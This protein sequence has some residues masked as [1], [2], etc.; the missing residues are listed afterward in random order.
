MYRTLCFN[1]LFYKPNSPVVGQLHRAGL[2]WIVRAGIAVKDSFGGYGVRKRVCNFNSPP[3]LLQRLFRA[4]IN[5]RVGVICITVA[6]A[7]ITV[8]LLPRVHKY[9]TQRDTFRRMLTEFLHS[10][11]I[12]KDTPEITRHA[13]AHTPIP[14][15]RTPTIHSHPDAAAERN[16][17][18]EFVGELALSIGRTPFFMSMARADQKAGYDGERLYYWTK[19][20]PIPPRFSEISPT[21]LVGIVDTDYYIDMPDLLRDN[22][23]PYIVYTIQPENAGGELKDAKYRFVDNEF[24]MI[25]TGGAKFRHEIWD[26]GSDTLS[27]SGWSWANLCYSYT[28]FLLERRNV[29][30]GR[31]LVLLSPVSRYTGL[32]AFL[33]SLFL[34]TPNLG[35]LRPLVGDFNVINL[36]GKE[37]RSVSVARNGSWES[38][39][40]SSRVD[41]TFRETAR[42]AEKQ[43]LGLQ[44]AQ[45]TSHLG[46]EIQ[47]P[48]QAAT[49]LTAYYASH[50]SLN[51][52]PTIY[53]VELAVASYQFSPSKYEPSTPTMK[54][55]MSP[56]L[57]P[58]PAPDNCLSNDER[59]VKMRITSVANPCLKPSSHVIKAM[60][61]FV[62]RLIPPEIRHTG[63]PTGYD[64]VFRRQPRPSQ[65]H[66]LRVADLM[67][68]AYTKVASCF[69]KKEDY[70]KV[71]DPRNITQVPGPEKSSYSRFM[72]AFAEVM[73]VQPWYA[74]GKT[75][76]EI[77]HCVAAIA[78]IVNKLLIS[79]LSRMDGHKSNV[80]R[81][82]NKAAVLLFFH[83]SHA[84]ELVDLMETQY[85]KRG[86]TQFGIWFETW[87][88]QLSGSPDTSI[89]NTLESG[90]IIFL[91]Y[92]CTIN[93]NTC[94]YYTFSE[95]WDCLVT[96]AMAGG[97]DGIAGDL[98]AASYVKAAKLLGHVATGDIVERGERGVTFLSRYYSPDV[99]SGDPA[100]CCDIKRAALKFHTTSRLPET[101][102]PLEKLAEK[103]LAIT[104]TDPNTP[105]LGDFATAFMTLYKLYGSGKATT[106]ER[107]W[108]QQYD[109]DVQFININTGGWMDEEVRMA[110]PEFDLEGFRAHLYQLT[111]LSDFL[112]FPIFQ[113]EP[114]PVKGGHAGVVVSGELGDAPEPVD[115][116]SCLTRHQCR[117]Y[118]DEGPGFTA[119]ELIALRDVLSMCEKQAKPACT[120]MDGRGGGGDSKRKSS[121]GGRKPARG[122]PAA[123]G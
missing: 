108:W 5:R 30:P 25:V 96:K 121:P 44:T 9:I 122:R 7:A 123:C 112:N 102:S 65:Q 20:T 70:G 51:E 47:N 37:G 59:C 40:I 1:M 60:N 92:T 98:E 13:F 55:F 33:A 39:T 73:K 50:F 6:S 120:A 42:R 95:A 114:T 111:S 80:G 31:Q 79:D 19:D 106:D 29:S 21:S 88:S 8:M 85:R 48:K 56:L 71:N 76:R 105:I 86:V 81:Q 66:I 115:L 84:D 118:W 53:P 2:H 67:G 83:P 15:L 87:L 27:V 77:S 68:E 46:P 3:S 32:R 109:S 100:T 43:K 24:E 116:A 49:L 52:G 26:Y 78:S 91:A 113:L 97:D 72:Y 69:Q 57:G 38:A 16:S 12:L 110:L 17:M 22:P 36:M 101:T 14:E 117:P 74:F 63:H 103:C 28:G 75:P 54:A 89:F 82:L 58:S 45:L 34:P 90:Y 64:E 11:D 104:S 61:Y 41:A 23:V 107:G 99:W 18:S 62:E 94:K 35:R 119:A 10:G 93:P 4:C